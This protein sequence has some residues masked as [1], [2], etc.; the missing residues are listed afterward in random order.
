MLGA[1]IREE[2]LLLQGF[3]CLSILSNGPTSDSVVVVVVVVGAPAVDVVGSS[4]CVDVDPSA[5]VVAVTVDSGV[6]SSANVVKKHSI[7]TR[8]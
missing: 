8:R 4:V 7:K 2:L 1:M 3:V 5:V 6:G